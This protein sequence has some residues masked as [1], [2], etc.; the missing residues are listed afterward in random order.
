M[1]TGVHHLAFITHDL[2]ATIRF[3]RDLLGFPLVAGMGSPSFKH[4][5]F[6]VTEK[7]QIAFFAYDQAQPMEK[8]FHGVPTDLP[9]GFDHVA[10]GVESKSDLFNM[11]DRLEAGGITVMGPVDHGIGWSIYFF[12]PSGIPLELVW[13]NMEI[14]LPP[15]MGDA[16]PPPS[17][18]EGSAPQP[19]N[20]PAVTRPTP[21]SEW[22]AYPGAGFELRAQALQEAR[23][24]VVGD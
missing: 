10:I 5:F 22:R 9:L 11:K 6:K 7:D 20:W 17:A 23:A 4:Y 14:F 13:S 21:K 3:Y 24:R 2:E 1:F 18:R 16:A 19:D 12:D 8:K 15:L